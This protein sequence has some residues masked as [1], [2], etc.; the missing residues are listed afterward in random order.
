MLMLQSP[1]VNSQK[2]YR[3]FRVTTQDQAGSKQNVGNETHAHANTLPSIRFAK[4]R[5]DIQILDYVAQEFQLDYR[6]SVPS[7]LTRSSDA[8]SVLWMTLNFLQSK[9][10]R[11]SIF[12]SFANATG[13]A[14]Q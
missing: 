9:G 14:E 6:A 3:E 8:G 13:R 11:E 5:A 2:A 1:V 7:K 4:S 10:G 12:N